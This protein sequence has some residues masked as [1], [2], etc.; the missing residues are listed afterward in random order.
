MPTVKVKFSVSTKYVGS[1]VTEDVYVDY[2]FEDEKENAI[3]DAFDRWIWDNI[4]TDWTE[5]E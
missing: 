4:S 5:I 3:E 2:D 1:E